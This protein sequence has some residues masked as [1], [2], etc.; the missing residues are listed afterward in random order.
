MYSVL[1]KQ[2][3]Y[4]T[5]GLCYVAEHPE[6]PGCLGCG[7]TPAD[8]QADLDAAREAYLASLRDDG[9]P[10]PCGQREGAQ[11]A[12]LTLLLAIDAGRGQWLPWQDDG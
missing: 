5:G 10:I 6:L 2:T 4:T 3:E 9:L 11:G 8:A 1:V 7:Q 12:E